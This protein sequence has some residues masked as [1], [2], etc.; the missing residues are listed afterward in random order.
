MERKDSW[1]HQMTFQEDQI[2]RCAETGDFYTLKSLLQAGHPIN[3][4]NP[5]TTDSPLMAACRRG[6]DQIV[7]LCLQYGARNDP[8]PDFGQTALH[9]AVAAGQYNCASIILQV[10]HQSE[11]DSIITNLTDQN[12]QTPLHVSSTLGSIPLV[13]LLLKHGAH[14]SSI[15]SH[16]QTALHLAAAAGHEPCLALLLDEGGDEII[17]SGDIHGNSPLH[18]AAYNGRLECAKLLLETAAN[19]ITRNS[20]GLTPYN[21][22]ITQ[23]HQQV[24]LLL[25]EYR[26]INAFKSTQTTPAMKTPLARRV[27][28][29][30]PTDSLASRLST[31]STRFDDSEYKTPNLANRYE[32]ALSIKDISPSTPLAKDSNFSKSLAVKEPQMLSES[33]PRPHTLNSLNSPAFNNKKPTSKKNNSN[34]SSLGSPV[35]LVR[36]TSNNSYNSDN[37]VQSK[38]VLGYSNFESLSQLSTPLLSRDTSSI[39]RLKLFYFIFLIQV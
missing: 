21:L 25:L 11:A 6:H 34:S 12:G 5:I 36:E 30:S 2:Y 26:D 18:H 4:L 23:G 14:L 22:A 39:S 15:D 32:V 17:E 24:G 28:P 3:F 8:H 29:F 27:S 37:F 35:E 1:K 20:K 13:K 16:G 31:P 33:L 19:S 38:P 7:D 9:A 10:A